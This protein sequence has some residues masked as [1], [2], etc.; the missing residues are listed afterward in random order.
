ME[1]TKKSPGLKVKLDAFTTEVFGRSRT[2]SIHDNICVICGR[3]ALTFRDALSRKEFA[4]SGMCQDCQD[5]I[6]KD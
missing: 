5:D 3:E 4:I 2:A 6:F 1:P